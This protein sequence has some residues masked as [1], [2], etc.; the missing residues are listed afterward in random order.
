MKQNNVNGVVEE[1]AQIQP[2]IYPTQPVGE[3]EED[4]GLGPSLSTTTAS[5]ETSLPVCTLTSEYCLSRS[6]LRQLNTLVRVAAKVHAGIKHGS[7][8]EYS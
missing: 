1:G 2:L 3:D 6:L 4:K 7:Q 8:S 5:S